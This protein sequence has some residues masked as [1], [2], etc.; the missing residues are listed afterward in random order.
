MPWRLLIQSLTH[1]TINTSPSYSNMGIWEHAI[2]YNSSPTRLLR[3]SRCILSRQTTTHKVHRTKVSKEG[4]IEDSLSEQGEW[5]LWTLHNRLHSDISV[6]W[7]LLLSILKQRG[8][9][10]ESQSSSKGCI[11]LPWLM[12]NFPPGY[13]QLHLVQLINLSFHGFISWYLP[14]QHIHTTH[15]HPENA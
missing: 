13:T 4:F 11:L 9:S 15:T 14:S 8:I 6:E 10:R 12:G 5:D 2:W 3:S 7:L 1:F